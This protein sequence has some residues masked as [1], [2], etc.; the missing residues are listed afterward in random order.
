MSPEAN[1]CFVVLVLGFAVLVLINRG[2][3]YTTS[4]TRNLIK[5][6]NGIQFYQCRC[7]PTGIH[8]NTQLTIPT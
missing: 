2:V 4:R 8:T 6:I 7:V 5:K 1:K 3:G